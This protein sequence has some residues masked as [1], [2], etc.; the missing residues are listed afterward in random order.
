M[1][2][3]TTSEKEAST[4]NPACNFGFERNIIVKAATSMGIAI[5]RIGK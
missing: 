2:L 1:E 3:I 4:L 5:S